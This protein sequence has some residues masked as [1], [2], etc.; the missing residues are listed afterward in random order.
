MQSYEIEGLPVHLQQAA[1]D[2]VAED[3]A[4]WRSE[5]P[6]DEEEESVGTVTGLPPADYAPWGGDGN[7]DGT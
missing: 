2:A 4:I 5:H 3:H 7:E 1:W 6:R